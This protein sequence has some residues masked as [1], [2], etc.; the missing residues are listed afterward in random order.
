M[1]KSKRS[2]LVAS[3]LLAGTSSMI[4]PHAGAASSAPPTKYLQAQGGSIELKGMSSVEVERDLLDLTARGRDRHVILDLAMA[5][6]DREAFE[7]KGVKLLSSLGG[8]SWVASIA[9]EAAAAAMHRLST[10]D[11]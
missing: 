3:L 11:A 2:T 5:N 10:I 6:P 4:L 7:K 9:P 1:Y 8:S